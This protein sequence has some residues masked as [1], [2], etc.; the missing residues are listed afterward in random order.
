[1]ELS[2]I[3]KSLFVFDF[4]KHFFCFFSEVP[5]SS[6]LEFVLLLVRASLL[7][8]KVQL[9]TSLSVLIVLDLEI[10]FLDPFCLSSKLD[11]DFDFVITFL[12]SEAVIFFA[13]SDAELTS[14]AKGC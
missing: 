13:F 11:L 6:F 12:G 4:A 3:F 8:C 10:G 7:E 2:E 14:L 9:F 5:F 1:M